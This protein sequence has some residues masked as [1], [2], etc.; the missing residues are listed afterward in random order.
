MLLRDIEDEPVLEL[1]RKP[2]RRGEKTDARKELTD[3]E[4]VKG[5]YKGLLKGKSLSRIEEEGGKVRFKRCAQFKGLMMSK[6]REEERFRT[7]AC[8]TYCY[9][10]LQYL[11]CSIFHIGFF[12][13]S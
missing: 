13:F 2:A 7:A 1:L 8:R 5:K 3:P 10:E 11:R 9:A 12:E 6:R 4:F